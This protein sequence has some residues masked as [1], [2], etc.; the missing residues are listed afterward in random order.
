MLGEGDRKEQPSIGHQAVV[1]E[2]YL[3]AVGLAGWQHLLGAPRFGSVWSFH[4]PLSPKRG[5]IFSSPQHAGTFTLSVDWGLE[6]TGTRGTYVGDDQVWYW[7]RGTGVGPRPCISALQALERACDRHIKQDIPIADLVAALLEGCENLAMVGLAVGILVRHLEVVDS[8]LD[9]YLADPLIWHLEF[10]RV[11][12]ESSMLAASSEGIESP[13]RRRWSL[14]EAAMTLGL[15]ANDERAEELRRIGETLVE[16]ARIIIGQEHA[17]DA[18]TGQDEGGDD[19]DPE[20]AKFIVWASCLDRDKFQVQETPD[21]LYVQPTPPAEAVKKLQDGNRDFERTS[22]ELRL[23]ARYLYKIKEA[24]T[25]SVGPDELA[26]DIKSA[27]QLLEDPAL[28]GVH[29]PWDVPVAVAALEAHLLRGVDLPDDLLAFA[30]ETILEVSEGAA[31]PQ[32]YDFEE[33]YFEQGADRSA[34]RA[35]PLLLMPVAAHLNAI[36]DGASGSA[37]F[38][39]ASVAGLNLAGA[40][41]N[42][43]RLHLARGLDHLWATPC[44]QEGSC[45]HEVGW[46][47]A[48]ATMRGC[49]LGGWDRNMGMPS[50]ILL[51]EPFTRS[52]ADIP[53]DSIQ[54]F[55]LDAAIRALAPAV[56]A[57][58]CVS[59]AARD[60]LTHLLH[61]QRRSLLYHEQN[62]NDMDDRGTHALVTARALLT[63]AQHG[64]DAAVYEQIDGYAD[65][66]T[67]LGNLLRA[68]SA[69]AEETPDRAAAARRIWPSV[70]RRVLDLNWE[71]HTP[72]E[73]QFYGD[74]ALAALIPNAASEVGYLYRELREQPNVWWDPF[75][76]QSEVEEWLGPAIGKA[77]CVD[78]L[79]SF[80]R[81]LTPE[82]QACLGIPWAATLVLTNPGNIANRSYLLANWLI[83]TRSAADAVGLA[84]KWQEIVDALVVEGDTRLAPYSE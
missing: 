1:V 36:I 79:V 73:G 25:D 37:T 47:L 24:H 57:N 67:P 56:T 13:E 41:V 68:L 50:V 38:E 12:R 14:R 55:R 69:A 45:H 33:S 19:I 39:R 10:R 31:S 65:K 26:A 32:L 54:P 7:Y 48:T 3:D 27:R 9:P 52:L 46:Q 11:V 51:N 16:N 81:V 22:E 78:Q 23:T 43:V 80:L 42:E 15:D 8:L 84:A 64:D 49:A 34:A 75:A 5:S 77:T 58:I 2:R 71:G 29:H 17:A 53:D 76:L 62:D 61:A 60:L 28:L 44:I 83:E 82:D 6:V 66:S 18:S 59:A 40:I 70:V 20:L 63:L 4:K 72:F 35:L 74:M 30:V 21:G